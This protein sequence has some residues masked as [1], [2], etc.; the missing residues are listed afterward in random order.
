MSQIIPLRRPN[1]SLTPADWQFIRQLGVPAFPDAS[2]VVERDGGKH[3]TQRGREFYQAAFDFHGIDADVASLSYADVLVY[4]IQVSNLRISEN[5]EQMHRAW[6]AGTIAAQ[7]RAWAEHYL[8]GNAAD[9]VE[10]AR[11]AELCEAAG[12]N[13]IPLPQKKRPLR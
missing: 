5:R 6:E 3:L 10:T 2:L 9:R 1:S 11:L 12:P 8:F 13:V 7:E 4:A